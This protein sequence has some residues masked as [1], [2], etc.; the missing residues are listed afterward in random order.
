MGLLRL[1]PESCYTMNDAPMSKK[2]VCPKHGFIIKLNRIVH[3][4]YWTLF[5]YQ[6]KVRTEREFFG[7]TN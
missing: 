7:E 1:N 6:Q 3:N 2:Y 4:F 5:A